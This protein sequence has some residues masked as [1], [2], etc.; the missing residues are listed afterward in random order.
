MDEPRYILR[1]ADRRF[2][3]W[4]TKDRERATQFPIE[5][6]EQYREEYQE[7][8]RAYYDYVNP[9]CPCKRC[10]RKREEA[11]SE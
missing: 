11:L 3:D 7:A 2:T 1:K 9:S 5:E 8:E 6:M 4:F 10:A